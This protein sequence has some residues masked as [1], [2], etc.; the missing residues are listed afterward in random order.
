MA[1]MYDEG[2]IEDYE[3]QEENDDGNI[4]GINGYVCQSCC[5]NSMYNKNK[6][7]ISDNMYKKSFIIMLCI[8]VVGLIIKIPLIN[9]IGFSIPVLLF[10]LDILLTFIFPM[11][12][13]TI[14][15]SSIFIKEL[16]QKI[17]FK[18]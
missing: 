1:F 4:C 15:C 9:I 3:D 7:I 10:I 13:V 11:F 12:F 16:Y 6:S 14:Y 5:D 2:Y 8:T 17:K 18:N